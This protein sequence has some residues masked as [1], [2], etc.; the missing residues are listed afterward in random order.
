MDFPSIE[1]EEMNCFSENDAIGP[2]PLTPA[3][4][5]QVLHPDISSMFE[6]EVCE[7]AAAARLMTN[8]LISAVL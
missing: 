1:G 2:E 8:A 7:N 4:E 6:N 3:Q 5:L